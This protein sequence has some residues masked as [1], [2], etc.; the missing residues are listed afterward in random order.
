MYNYWGTIVQII[1]S[2][3]LKV[4]LFKREKLLSAKTQENH[5]YA[6]RYETL[7]QE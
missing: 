1:H 3:S 2:P 6:E 7:R 5:I 4:E